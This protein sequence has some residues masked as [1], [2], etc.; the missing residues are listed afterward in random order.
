MTVSD[1]ISSCMN[2]M[3]D[4]T[5]VN[6]YGRHSEWLQCKAGCVDEQWRRKEVYWWRIN[7]IKEDGLTALDVEIHVLDVAFMKGE[8]N[9]DSL[10]PQYKQL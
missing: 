6:L 3:Y 5:V 1:V 4:V 7:R 9:N 8:I 10:H 2:I